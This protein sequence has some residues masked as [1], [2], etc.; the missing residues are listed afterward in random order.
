[1]I[2]NEKF[3]FK[4]LGRLCM[5]DLSSLAATSYKTISSSNKSKTYKKYDLLF[6]AETVFKDG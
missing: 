2:Q 4:V 3:W 1:M 6:V 5:S